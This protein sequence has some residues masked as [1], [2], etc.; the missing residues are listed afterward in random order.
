LFG[1]ERAQFLTGELSPVEAQRLDLEELGI[2][3]L[4]VAAAGDAAGGT[5][6]ADRQKNYAVGLEI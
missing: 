6:L 1:L 3:F 2:D 4:G 5:G